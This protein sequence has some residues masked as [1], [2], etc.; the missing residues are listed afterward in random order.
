MDEDLGAP[1][2]SG[3]VSEVYAHPD[4]VLKLYRAYEPKTSAFR[5]AAAMARAAALG[6][7]VP[8]VLSV[9]RHRDRW[10]IVMTRAT[11]P[12][13][14]ARLGGDG[15]SV[16]RL[17]DDMARLHRRLHECEAGPLPDMKAGLASR[18]ARA[19]HL[20]DAGRRRLLDRLASLPDG[21]GLCHG[22][23]HPLNVLGSREAPVVVDWLDACRGAA[24][25]DVC[26]SYVLLRP[27]DATLA[28]A[29]LSAYAAGGATSRSEV[30]AWRPCVAAARLTEGVAETEALLAMAAED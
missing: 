1:I 22:D 28:E 4:G 23:F 24:A 16:A 5:E 10:G 11:G 2:G 7:P 25:A 14:G 3:R 27:H 30:M 26:R 6:L 20:G 18:I 21:P 13:L 12:D 19:P 8:E 15:D 29:Y 9:G 17:A